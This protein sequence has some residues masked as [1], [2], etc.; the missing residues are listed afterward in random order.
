MIWVLS[1]STRTERHHRGT[2]GQS[3]STQFKFKSLKITLMPNDVAS[4]LLPGNNSTT[5]CS[6][7]IKRTYWGRITTSRR[8][9][10][11]LKKNNLLGNPEYPQRHLLEWQ[12]DVA[13]FPFIVLSKNV[14]F[15][16]N[17]Y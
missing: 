5:Y 1:A 6:Y 15:F 9:P 8:T 16:K 11:G 3:S 10:T 12:S 14:L 7:Q 2:E 17:R 4:M 13:H